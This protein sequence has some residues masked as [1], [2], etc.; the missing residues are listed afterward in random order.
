MLTLTQFRYS[1]DNFSYVVS[2]PTSA[3]AVDPG[4]VDE[5]LAFVDARGLD[6]THV[7]NTHTHPDHTVGNT[8]L[9][10]RSKAT[11][12]DIPTL[13]RQ[14]RL[15]I[16]GEPLFVHYTPG[17]MDDCLTFEIKGRLI[18]GDTLF[19]GTVGTCFSGDMESFYRS[20]T[21]LLT[22]PDDTKIYAGHD[23]VQES[24]AFARIIEPENE[25]EIARYLTLY[26]PAHVVSTLGDEKRA[27]PFLRFNEPNLVRTMKQR[28]LPVATERDRW[29]S[30]MELY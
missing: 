8:P 10:L 19:N 11:H 23:Y 22:F 28:D 1:A 30:V 25:T 9:I 15:E 27:N 12:L 17:H 16:D 13:R 2:G 14:G 18:T 21:F 26:D 3:V 4:A 7:I 5:I 20:V 6:L 24:M 29:H